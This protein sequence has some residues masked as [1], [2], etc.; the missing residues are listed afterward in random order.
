MMLRSKAL[1]CA[2]LALSLALSFALSLPLTPVAHAGLMCARPLIVHEWGVQVFGPD[3]AALPGEPLPDFFHGPGK[4]LAFTP[5]VPVRDLPRDNGMRELPVM[6]FYSPAAA[7]GY[8]ATVPFALDVGFA[9]GHATSWFPDAD[10]LGSGPKQLIWSRLDLL[11]TP[12]FAPAKTTT[13]WVERARQVPGLWVNSARESERFVFYEGRTREQVPLVIRRA[14]GWTQTA[15]KLEIANVGGHPVHDVM[16]VQREGKLTRV[17]HFA[18]IQPGRS[19]AF[20][21]DQSVVTDVAAATRGALDKA[22]VDARAPL[23]AADAWDR[24]TCVM[25]RD[26]AVAFSRADGHRLYRAEVDLLLSV[27]GERF[28]GGD[29]TRIVY[30]EDTA[31]L[32]EVMPVSLYTDM[33]NYIMLQRAGLVL[34]SGVVLP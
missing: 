31:Y 11:P 19:V 18:D 30:R 32:D 1:S 27:W 26:P 25:D 12:T 14:A 9:K 10:Q 33:Y 22:L 2:V 20:D 34:W 4:T 16:F 8:T 6:H 24:S 17:H 21:L 28:F 29:G 15:R 7:A 23:P 5:Q 13:A 3:G